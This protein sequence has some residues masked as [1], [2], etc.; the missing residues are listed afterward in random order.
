MIVRNK[1]MYQEADHAAQ[2]GG[3]DL[4]HQDWLHSQVAAHKML[5]SKREKL[6]PS[7]VPVGPETDPLEK[8]AVELS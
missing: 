2:L 1:L 6:V 5:S 4:R 3:L 7:R 8:K